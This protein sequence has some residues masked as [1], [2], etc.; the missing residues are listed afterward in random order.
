V[1]DCQ[2]HVG[3]SL[4]ESSWTNPETW[5][6]SCE[7]RLWRTLGSK[8]ELIDRGLFGA[9]GTV[10]FWNGIMESR[11]SRWSCWSLLIRPQRRWGAVG[12]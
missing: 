6:Q 5:L 10:R 7:R 8:A 2:Y 1:H 9:D 12:S 11:C 4:A 3:R